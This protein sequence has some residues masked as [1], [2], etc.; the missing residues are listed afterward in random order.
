MLKKVH[1]LNVY[2]PNLDKV[3]VKGTTSNL[4]K[5]VMKRV[6]KKHIYM[7]ICGLLAR[8]FTHE[9]KFNNE[10][11]HKRNRKEHLAMESI[12][13]Y[14]KKS[15]CCKCVRVCVSSERVQVDAK[16]YISLFL[17]LCWFGFIFTLN[18]CKMIKCP[19]LFDSNQF[20]NEALPLKTYVSA[21]VD[22][23]HVIAQKFPNLMGNLFI[24]IAQ[25]NSP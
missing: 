3:K 4:K 24:Y 16:S 11:H 6:Q 8:G 21:A 17:F 13:V 14:N 18:N 2:T 23:T 10:V 12:Y 15:W 1:I 22:T 20:F 5:H 9:I 19:F 25:L 7:K